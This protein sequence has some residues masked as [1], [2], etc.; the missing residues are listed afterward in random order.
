MESDFKGVFTRNRGDFLHRNE[1]T[2]VL[3]HGSTFVCTIPLQNVMPAL[4]TLVVVPVREFYSTT[5]FC[6]W[7]GTG[8]IMHNVYDFESHVYFIN[9]ECTFK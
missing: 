4:V 8:S 5:K 1:F 3:S 2:P 7:T 6:G 9:M